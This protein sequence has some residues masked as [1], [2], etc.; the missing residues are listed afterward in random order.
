MTHRP[1]LG[2]LAVL[3][4]V[5]TAAV[6][7]VTAPDEREVRPTAVAAPAALVPVL[8]AP[9]AP[10]RAV[11]SGR[12]DQ[13]R[14][15]ALTA[16]AIDLTVPRVV[17]LHRDAGGVLEMPEDG[18]TGWSTA[19]PTPGALGPAVLTADD[20]PGPFARITELAAG[21]EVTVTREDGTHAVFSVYRVE[22]FPRAAFPREDVYGDTGA[23]ELRLVT[24][25]G[26]F[27]RDAE[28]DSANVVAFAR[29]AGVR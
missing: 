27:E 22:R 8:A 23:A 19:G 12:L 13:A 29:L 7:L 26:V 21:D 17:E 15:V 2:V 18:S 24:S 4:A 11:P 20:G 28:P 16:P 25:G 6:L 9:D 3:G 10:L 1:S 14:P 5:V